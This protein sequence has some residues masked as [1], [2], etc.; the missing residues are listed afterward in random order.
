MPS[1][2]IHSPRTPNCENSMPSLR[3]Q[4]MRSE[5]VIIG[6]K[7]LPGWK[8]EGRWMPRRPPAVVGA[9]SMNLSPARPRIG[10]H[11][12]GPS[13]QEIA[14]DR[15]KYMSLLAVELK[16]F[17]RIVSHPNHGTSRSN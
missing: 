9:G 4:E 15:N 3:F 14:H 1:R 6:G 12:R 11:C 17:P 5:T 7:P 2:H 13:A 16:R 10:P 8:A